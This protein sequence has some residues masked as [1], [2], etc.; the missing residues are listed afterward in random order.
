MHHHTPSWLK[1]LVQLRKA[2]QHFAILLKLLWVFFPGVLL[3]A[4]AGHLLTHLLQ[5]QDV[6]MIALESKTR[7]FFVMTGLVF[8]AVVAWYSSRLIAYNKD[9]LFEL[10]P[11]G[12]YHA[13]RLIGYGCFAA[14]L[15]AFLNLPVLGLPDRLPGWILAVDL[16]LYFVFH[17]VFENI[18][19]RHDEDALDKY[20]KMDIASLVLIFVACGALNDARAYALLIPPLQI[21]LLYLVVVR[22]KIK[23]SAMHKGV[24][25]KHSDKDPDSRMQK[26]LEWILTDNTARRPADRK[27]YILM[28]ELSI[29]KSFNTI[30]LISVVIYLS[31][32]FSL[33]SSRFISPFPIV[34]LA[35]GVLVGFANMITLLSIKFKIN[36]HFLYVL[37]VILVGAISEPHNVRRIPPANAS[38]G[39]MYAQRADLQQYFSQWIKDRTEEISDPTTETYPVFLTLADGGASRS[40]Y[41]TASVLSR[42]EDDTKGRFSRHLFCLSGASGG[43]V[44]NAAFFASLYS[45]KHNGD[46]YSNLDRC[47]TYLSNDF[48]SFTLARLLGPDIFKPIF[49]FDIIHDRAAALEKSM[50]KVPDGSMMGALM[51]KPFS[52]YSLTGCNMPILMI[53]AT[54]MQDGR[55]GVISTIRIDTAVF[56][57]RLDVLGRLIPWKDDV[58]LST[59]M[60]LGARFPYVSPAGRINEDYYVDGGYFDNSGAG[61]VHEIIMELQRIIADSLEKNPSHR[62]GKLRFHVIHTTNAPKGESPVKK[63]HPL[64]ND[65][66]APISTLLGS[67]STQTHVNNLRLMRYLLQINKGDTTYIP[68]NLYEDGEMDQ[69][70][71]NWVISRANLDKM[72]A[73]L[74]RYAKL[75]RFIDA[76]NR[77]DA[78]SLRN[79]FSD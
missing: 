59:M 35:M 7:G 50:E 45:G 17:R 41:W 37:L 5:G 13:P 9:S 16:A 68:F 38:V 46:A 21:G 3:I 25:A 74:A 27:Q 19:D 30:S 66:A 26:I 67:Y 52:D 36:F 20:R 77:K 54:R 15:Y 48:L 72:N 73:R 40:G 11:Q 33:S 64:V 49:P 24:E 58:R 44:G 51:N 61:V 53:N 70:P 62:L 60:V 43:S 57:K 4:I 8:W 63:V 42:I 56:G 31:A 28:G 32:V 47:R 79:L 75:D 22:R 39:N 78:K 55:P 2:L 6:V 76:L 65:L 69:Y 10:F 34:L 71:M 14:I 23:E 1:I 18:R 29:F 12:L